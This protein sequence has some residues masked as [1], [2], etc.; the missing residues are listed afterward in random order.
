MNPE[1]LPRSSC[2]RDAP[3]VNTVSDPRQ[4]KHAQERRRYQR[5][6]LAMG[7]KGVPISFQAGRMRSKGHISNVSEVGLFITCAAV[8]ELRSVFQAEFISPAGGKIAVAGMVW[9]TTTGEESAPRGFGIRLLE[10]D[11]AYLEFLENILP[12]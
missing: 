1:V 9:R 11:D 10:V 3:I 5:A 4:A 6:D 12:A 7:G 2:G 8:P